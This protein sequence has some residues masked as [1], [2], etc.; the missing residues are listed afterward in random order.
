MMWNAGFKWMFLIIGT[1]IGAGYAS[2]RELW[3]FFGHE[4]GLA[5]LLFIIFFTVCC[6]DI[7]EISYKKQSSDYTQVLEIIVGIKL[8]RFYDVMILFYLYTTTVV[9]ISGSGSTGQ[10]FNFS[11]W[12]GIGFIVL[13]LII[14]F[15]RDI[16]GVLI[17]NQYILPILIAGLLFV[18]LQFTFDQKLALF[19]HW[20]DRKSTRLNSSHVAI[21]YAVFCL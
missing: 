20:Q 9:M 19:S 8:V 17:I 14:L 21:S 18:L 2:G 7:I 10:A 1:T 13:T 16:N 6:I 11:Y 4:S 12:W 15:I 3:E 5:I